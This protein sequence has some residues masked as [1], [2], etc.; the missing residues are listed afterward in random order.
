MMCFHVKQLLFQAAPIWM[1]RALFH[2]KLTTYNFES[3]HD[4]CRDG[5]H[6]HHCHKHS[7]ITPIIDIVTLF[8]LCVRFR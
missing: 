4:Y 2:S 6:G 7:E 5:L 1:F 8:C 3:L